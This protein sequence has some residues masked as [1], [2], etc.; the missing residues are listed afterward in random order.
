MMLLLVLAAALSRHIICSLDSE[1]HCWSST[2]GTTAS[3]TA[4]S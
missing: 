3:A 2:S 1:T 4:S